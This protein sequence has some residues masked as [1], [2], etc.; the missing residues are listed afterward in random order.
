MRSNIGDIVDAMLKPDMAWVG[1]AC[2]SL[3]HQILESDFR[4]ECILG[5]A[6]GGLVPAAMLSALLRKPLVVVRAQSYDGTKHQAELIFDVGSYTFPKVPTLVVDDIADS[7]KTLT[8]MQALFNSYDIDVRYATL[9]RKA[10]STVI[11]DW[12]ACL[13]DGWV[14]YPWEQ[15]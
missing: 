9:H 12:S 4:P 2:L 8:F 1:N 6:Y 10:Q 7:G 15:N 3:Y 13:V 5:I 11:P 14:K